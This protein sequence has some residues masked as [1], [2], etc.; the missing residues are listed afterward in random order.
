MDIG[1]LF[2]K[3]SALMGVNILRDVNYFKDPSGRISL[4]FLSL[5]PSASS[6]TSPFKRGNVVYQSTLMESR[7]GSS[8]RYSPAL[9]P[10][11]LTL[12]PQQRRLQIDVLCLPLPHIVSCFGGISSAVPLKKKALFTKS[13]RE[14][15]ELV[16]RMPS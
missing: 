2:N 15:A 9:S 8:R 13:R 1:R 11:H 3:T 4:G 5:D 7:P 16:R 12:T 6:L 14:S 10:P